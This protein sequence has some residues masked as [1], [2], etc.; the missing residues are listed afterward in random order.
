MRLFKTHSAALWTK[1]MVGLWLAAGLGAVASGST[2]SGR[3]EDGLRHLPVPPAAAVLHFTVIRGDAIT[4]DLSSTDAPM[5]LKI[6]DLGIAERLTADRTPPPIFKMKSSGQFPL[7]LDGREG[8]LE[9]VDYQPANYREMTAAAAAA[10]A[11]RED[12]LVLDVR[13]P[14]EF[15]RGHLPNAVLIP[16]QELQ[17]R[18]AELSAYRQ[19]DILVYCATGS[20]STVASKILIDQ[21]FTRIANL[22]YGIVDWQQRNYPVTR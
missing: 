3:L 16:V 15:Q 8:L 1:L 4:F 21:G 20:R 12:P 10:F 18:I 11:A 9:V 5:M 7:T 13:T 2:I 6:P 17:R 22:R 14:A 19:R